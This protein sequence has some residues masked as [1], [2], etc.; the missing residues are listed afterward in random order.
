MNKSFWGGKMNITKNEEL[1]NI[2]SDILKHH[3][4]IT[5]VYFV[6]CGA[7]RADLYPAYYFLNHTSHTL[8]SSIHTA[9]EF[10]YATPDAVDDN[11][12]VIT[13]SLGGSTPETARATSVAKD[14][15]AA[16]IA[17]THTPGSPITKDANYVVVFDWEN[18]Y[19]AKMDKM[20][21]VLILAVEILNQSEGYKKYKEMW[22]AFSKIYMAIDN[23]VKSVLPDAKKFANEYKNESMIYVT[24]SGATQEVAWAFASCLL[25]EMQ[26]I[27]AATFNSGD[28]FHGPFEMVEIEAP[29]LLFMNEG[30]TRYLDSR[31][32]TFMQRFDCKLTVVDSKD[33]GLSGIVDSEIVD[34]FDP[35]M[36]SPIIRIY[37]EQLAIVRDHPLTKR[38]YMWK[39][40]Y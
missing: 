25:M 30:R 33:F 16:T 23:A 4:K 17:V 37:A 10:V 24:S 19:S 7:S 34:Y 28:F 1:I 40:K 36:I 31:A 27:P 12:I 9:N 26:W 35:I 22:A 21:K 20:I 5:H 8:A 3:E 13:C 39:L 2:V 11:S 29:Y 18:G 6:G 32:M 15:G 38:R 14:K